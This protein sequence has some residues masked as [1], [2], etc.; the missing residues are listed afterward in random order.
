MIWFL[1]VKETAKLPQTCGPGKAGA[2]FVAI[3]NSLG[4]N[5]SIQVWLTEV[6]RSDTQTKIHRRTSFPYQY[7][8]IVAVHFSFSV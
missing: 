1:D 6:T 4:S 8:E 2:R 7:I 5:D 3:A